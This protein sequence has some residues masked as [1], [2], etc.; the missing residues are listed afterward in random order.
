MPFDAYSI[1]EM[2]G[3]FQMRRFFCQIC[4]KIKHVRVM[5]SD[6]LEPANPIVTQRI[7]TCRYH[8]DLPNAKLF[9]RV[10]VRSTNIKSSRLSASAQKSKSK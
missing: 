8:A 5:P 3:Y 10:Q 6:V 4:H 9:S 1:S 2:D 7:G